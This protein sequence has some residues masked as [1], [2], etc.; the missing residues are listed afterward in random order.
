MNPSA[1]QN[2]ILK[3]NPQAPEPARGFIHSLESFGTVDGPGT[4][5]V[6]FFQG[7]PMRCQFCHNPDTWAP[8]T[9]K[10]MTV[11][12][13]LSGYRRGAAFYRRGGITAT[14]G[15]PLMQLSFLTELFLAAKKEGI[16]TCLD[17]AGSLYH[18]DLSDRYDALFS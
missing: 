11:E 18:P 12:E 14:G 3:N 2:T 16:H 17:T 8:H 15:E 10:E 7:C 6:V 5:Y 1:D 9:G 13:L 4:R